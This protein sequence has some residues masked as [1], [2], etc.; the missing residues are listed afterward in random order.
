MNNQIKQIKNQ[1]DKATVTKILK[2][3]CIAGGASFGIVVLQALASMDFG[4][5]TELVVGITAIIINAIRE[6]RKGE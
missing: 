1:F 2:G 4:P 5:Y 6:Y 3:A